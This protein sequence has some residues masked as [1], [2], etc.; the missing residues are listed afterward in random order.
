MFL[1]LTVQDFCDN[2]HNFWRNFEENFAK[3]YKKIAVILKSE[4]VHINVDTN[5][6]KNA[7]EIEGRVKKK[8]VEK[9]A[10]NL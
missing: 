3:W 8:I 9:V 5:L 6:E 1:W 4:A 2:L 10:N 7:Q